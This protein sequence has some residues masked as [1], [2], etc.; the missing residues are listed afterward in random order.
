MFCRQRESSL[1]SGSSLEG[2]CSTSN[3]T[4][5]CRPTALSAVM[6]KFNSNQI[7]EILELLWQDLTNTAAMDQLL[8]CWKEWSDVHYSGFDITCVDL[9]DLLGS[10]L[11]ER[12]HNH[13]DDTGTFPMEEV[14]FD[15]KTLK[16]S[17]LDCEIYTMISM[18]T[19]EEIK[20]SCPDLKEPR[21][22]IVMRAEICA[23]LLLS[24]MNDKRAEVLNNV[25]DF[26][27]KRA[28][29]IPDVLSRRKKKL[30]DDKKAEKLKKEAA[31]KEK[32]LEKKA[33]EKDQAEEN[34]NENKQ[35]EDTV[36]EKHQLELNDNAAEGNK[37]PL[38]TFV[39][40]KHLKRNVP[41]AS[42]L[43]EPPEKKKILHK[44]TAKKPT[45]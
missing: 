45:A 21:K 11:D 29:V 33:K 26:N 18:L 16:G 38:K 42:D 39:S 31:K 6:Q 32:E 14:E 28:I 5:Q 44:R 41:D 23:T 43:V 17:D 15:W 20:C 1:S 36:K 7:K 30:A 19:F 9:C 37:Q 40:R 10:F 3:M 13:E 12:G 25:A 2:G 8:V 34:A 4:T 35:P 22:R 24:D 27:S